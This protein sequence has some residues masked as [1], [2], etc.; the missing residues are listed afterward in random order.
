MD[1]QGAGMGVRSEA[2]DWLEEA[3]ADL[4]HARLSLGNGSYNWACFAAQQ[5]AEKALKAFMMGVGRRRPSRTHDLTRL[6]VMVRERLKL[7]GEVVERLG[8]LS[9]YYT[10]ARYP[11]AGLT[12]PST[13]ITRVQAEEAITLAGKV[14]ERVEDELRGAAEG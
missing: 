9:A 10:I 3:K 6:H 7:P 1:V 11:N 14:V 13:G 5:A 4:E 12:R 2:L 8:E